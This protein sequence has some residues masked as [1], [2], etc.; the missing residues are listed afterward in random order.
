[1]DVNV[2]RTTFR[3]KSIFSMDIDCL[4]CSGK[5][6]QVIAKGEEYLLFLEK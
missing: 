1:M 6:E 3:A 4:T 2:L 5:P